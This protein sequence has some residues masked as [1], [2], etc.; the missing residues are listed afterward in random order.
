MTYC[1]K[2]AA[3]AR[4]SAANAPKPDRKVAFRVRSPGS[5]N[6]VEHHMAYRFTDGNLIGACYVCVPIK[7]PDAVAPLSETI[8]QQEVLRPKN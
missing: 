7:R 3:S 2:Q 8:R 1:K 6:A 5:Y 4:V